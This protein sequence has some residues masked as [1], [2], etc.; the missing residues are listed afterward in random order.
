MILAARLNP[1]SNQI[2]HFRSTA[3][4]NPRYCQTHYERPKGHCQYINDIESIILFRERNCRHILNT[5]KFRG[6]ACSERTCI[7]SSFKWMFWINFHNPP[8]SSFFF[9]AQNF[10]NYTKICEI[11][12][13]NSFLAKILAIWMRMRS[14][15]MYTLFLWAT[16]NSGSVSCCLV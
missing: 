11:Y 2:Q 12:F 9:T 16:Q 5:H 13:A 15:F 8:I 14:K 10:V 6:G 4:L 1:K 7:S 3:R